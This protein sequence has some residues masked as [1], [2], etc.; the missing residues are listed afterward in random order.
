MSKSLYQKIHPTG[1]QRPRMY[2][3][4]KNAQ[5]KCTVMTDIV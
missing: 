2:C 1:S 4:L 3:L 5:N